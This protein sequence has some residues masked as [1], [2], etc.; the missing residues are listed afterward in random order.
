VEEEVQLLKNAGI[1]NA[2]MQECRNSE[3]KIKN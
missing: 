1:Q 3:L 2:G